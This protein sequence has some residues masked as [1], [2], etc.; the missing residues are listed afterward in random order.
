MKSYNF[1]YIIY[2]ILLISSAIVT[3]SCIRQEAVWMNSSAR[4]SD[5]EITGLKIKANRGDWRA[6]YRLFKH[7][8]YY[9]RR[10]DLAAPYKWG[11]DER[12]KRSAYY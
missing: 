6:A 2:L 4:L 12:N 10:E 9:E 11:A 3:S 8:E 1:R 7:Y 5:N